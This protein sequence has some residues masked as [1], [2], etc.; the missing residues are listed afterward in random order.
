MLKKPVVVLLIF[1][2]SPIILLNCYSFY[3]K[4]KTSPLREMGYF[5]NEEQFLY[6]VHKDDL[7]AVKI[8][9]DLGMDVNKP[10]T[11]EGRNALFIAVANENID[12]INLLIKEGIDVNKKDGNKIPII[13]YVTEVIN[14]NEIYEILK[15]AGAEDFTYQNYVDNMRIIDYYK[16]LRKTLQEDINN[17][18]K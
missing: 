9:I 17:A 2:I 6:A 5:Y 11:F 13:Y 10:I 18:F 16:V 4:N 7:K 3:Y 14:N 15:A 1:L 12:M 8:F